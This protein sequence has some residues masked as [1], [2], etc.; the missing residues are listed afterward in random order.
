MEN[1]FKMNYTVR[2]VNAISNL[3]LALIGDGAVATKL[4]S[5]LKNF[6]VNVIMIPS[7]VEWRTV[8]LEE[9]FKTA[10]L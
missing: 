8:S 2:Q 10:L 9:A 3:A 4:A 5:L 1:L 6:N 7:R